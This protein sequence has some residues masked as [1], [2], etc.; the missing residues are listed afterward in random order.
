MKLFLLSIDQTIYEET[1]CYDLTNDCVKWAFELNYCRSAE[2][3]EFMSGAC[4]ES[5]SFCTGKF[6]V[7]TY[8]LSLS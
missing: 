6:A 8:L 7:L 3:A 5:C 4:K 1:D 2:Y